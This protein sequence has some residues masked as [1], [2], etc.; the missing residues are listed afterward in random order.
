MYYYCARG[1]GVQH[2]THTEARE[3]LPS[4]YEFQRLDAQV[5]FTQ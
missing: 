2:G 1:R 3:Q 5:A 4:L